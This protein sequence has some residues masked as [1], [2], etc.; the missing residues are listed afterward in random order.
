MFHIV[1]DKRERGTEGTTAK[2]WYDLT[3]F[4]VRSSPCTA[5]TEADTLDCIEIVNSSLY[6]V[7][8]RRWGG[9]L[10]FHFNAHRL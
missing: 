10:T 9:D 2:K 6:K 1:K 8:D 5:D 3:H 4:L 7:G